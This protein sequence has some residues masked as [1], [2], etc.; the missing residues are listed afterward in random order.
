M[1]IQKASSIASA[2]RK[3][4]NINVNSK[5]TKLLISF[6]HI[7]AHSRIS[8][9]AT[10]SLVM[11]DF[12]HNTKP[13]DEDNLLASDKEEDSQTLV[14]SASISP[15]SISPDKVPSSD[16]G[17]IHDTFNK[18]IVTTPL[19]ALV[20]ADI[21]VLERATEPLP[22]NLSETNNYKRPRE[23]NTETSFSSIDTIPPSKRPKVIVMS[24]SEEE[25][26]VELHLVL[27]LP[28]TEEDSLFSKKH[29]EKLQPSVFK[30]IKAE[31]NP[32]VKFEFCGADRGRF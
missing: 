19:K 30:A 24:D 8:Y 28:D 25:T 26:K 31:I 6:V 15:V 5:R 22:V 29:C 21:V 17:R 14:S 4:T 20:K 9:Y 2:V 32:Q 16:I 11:S 13:I 3:V 1:C 27:L 7:R 18:L 10:F 23:P 12:S